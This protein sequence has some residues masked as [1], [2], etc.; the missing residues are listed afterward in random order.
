[1]DLHVQM[2]GL[3]AVFDKVVRHF[4]GRIA[5]F[6]RRIAVLDGLLVVIGCRGGNLSFKD[7]SLLSGVAICFLERGVPGQGLTVLCDSGLTM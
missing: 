6:G 1:M 7:L 3:H 5:V 4:S 2:D